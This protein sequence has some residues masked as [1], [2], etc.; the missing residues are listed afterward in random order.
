MTFFFIIASNFKI[1]ILFLYKQENSLNLNTKCNSIDPMDDLMEIDFTKKDE[2]SLSNDSN[3]EPKANHWPCYD[4]METEYSQGIEGS[5]SGAR[6]MSNASQIARAS[7]PVPIAKRMD[8]ENDG[9]MCMKPV[10]SSDSKAS[11]NNIAGFNNGINSTSLSSSPTKFTSVRST[12]NASSVS[13]TRNS[14]QTTRNNQSMVNSTDDYLMS[15]VNARSIL[16]VSSQTQNS[17]QQQPQQQQKQQTNSNSG[18]APDGYMEMSFTNKTQTNNSSS[19][20]INNNNINN[21]VN[22]N[23]LE[24]HRQSSSSSISSSNEYINM[25]FNSIPRTSSA[26]S[27]CSSTSSLEPPSNSISHLDLRNS[28]L[29]SNP[30]AIVGK[31]Q[32]QQNVSHPKQTLGNQP[33]NNMQNYVSS[34]VNA[35]SFLNLNN[36]INSNVASDS[37][38]DSSVTTPVADSSSQSSQNSSTIFPFS[39][40]SPNSGVNKQI[41]SSQQQPMPCEEQKRKCLVDGTTGNN[42]N[43]NYA[44][45]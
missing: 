20:T 16:K 19:N 2:D 35:P 3:F 21:N 8:A 44:R 43:N 9:Y 33:S 23:S 27:D 7:Q 30:I 41:F 14:Q 6:S 42:I 39:P 10:G 13:Q 17:H 38:S 22:S 12:S 15:P 36:T 37:M 29:R 11:T 32:T 26:S 40:N 24:R 1:I 25:N 18:S 4:L 31:Q 34:K 45:E 28:R 5:H